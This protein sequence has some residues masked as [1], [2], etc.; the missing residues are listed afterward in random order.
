MSNELGGGGYRG[1]VHCGTETVKIEGWIALYKGL[2]P[3]ILTTVPY[4][5][6]QVLL[7]TQYSRITYLFAGR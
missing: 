2:T 6:C 5:A 7:R 4:I 3:A 1:I